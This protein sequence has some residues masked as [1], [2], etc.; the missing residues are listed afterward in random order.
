[1]HRERAAASSRTN[2]RRSRSRPERCDESLAPPFIRDRVLPGPTDWEA[3]PHIF[4][5]DQDPYNG[6]S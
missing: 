6:A 2:A 4:V 3:A 1:M 5:I